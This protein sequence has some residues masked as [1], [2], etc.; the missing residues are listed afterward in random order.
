MD[1]F[2]IGDYSMNVGLENYYTALELMKDGLNAAII[3]I[4]LLKQCNI[5]DDERIL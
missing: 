4:S 5:Y 2:G 1:T 3:V